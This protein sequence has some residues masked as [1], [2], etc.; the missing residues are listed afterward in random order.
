[1]DKAFEK[2]STECIEEAT[3]SGCNNNNGCSPIGM[4][5]NINVYQTFQTLYQPFSTVQLPQQQQQPP[6]SSTYNPAWNVDKTYVSTDQQ[7][8]GISSCAHGPASFYSSI[9]KEGLFHDPNIIGQYSSGIQYQQTSGGEES[10]HQPSE[11]TSICS[12]S[13]L[14]ITSGAYPGSGQQGGGFIEQTGDERRLLSTQELLQPYGEE[15]QLPANSRLI[16]Q[17]GEQINQTVLLSE[18]EQRRL[19]LSRE[20]VRTGLEQF[21]GLATSTNPLNSTSII[22]MSSGPSGPLINPFTQLAGSTVVT[23]P[24]EVIYSEG[25]NRTGG[26]IIINRSE[27]EKKGISA[28]ARELRITFDRSETFWQS[29]EGRRIHA[30][31]C[32]IMVGIFQT[33]RN[34]QGSDE[35]MKR[36]FHFYCELLTARGLSMAAVNNLINAWNQATWKGKI[37][38]YNH[39][40]DFLLE[41][42]GMEENFDSEL[43]LQTLMMEFLDWC[44]LEREEETNNVGIRME[45][46]GMQI[47]KEDEENKRRKRARIAQSRRCY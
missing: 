27:N 11:I 37:Y 18:N 23:S 44:V 6:I 8:T 25:N 30:Q 46:E 22:Q 15:V 19:E 45:A 13:G 7:S 28:T 40:V 5:S 24:Q 42:S 36:G 10:R 14:Y 1:M 47:D 3:A 41:E 35:K 31:N 29:A 2:E 26:G 34:L 9:D 38:G 21:T 12:T 16:C 43:G 32:G 17:Q 33:L 20:C 39:F 4:G